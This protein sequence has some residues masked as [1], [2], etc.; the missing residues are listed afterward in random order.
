MANVA[1]AL[2]IEQAVEM[3]NVMNLNIAVHVLSV[4]TDLPNVILH[5]VLNS[6][7]LLGPDEYYRLQIYA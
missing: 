6:I 1:N 3:D 2:N 4:N 5:E 7:N